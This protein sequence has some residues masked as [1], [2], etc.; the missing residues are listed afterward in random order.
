MNQ[1]GNAG[2]SSL[3]SAQIRSN[4]YF[5]AAAAAAEQELNSYFS[6]LEEKERD[7]EVLVD[8]AQFLA[9]GGYNPFTISRDAVRA[10]MATQPDAHERGTVMD[11]FALE[12]FKY[13]ATLDK[14]LVRVANGEAITPLL[15]YRKPYTKRR[16]QIQI[17]GDLFTNERG[18]LAYPIATRDIDVVTGSATDWESMNR[19]GGIWGDSSMI[20]DTARDGTQGFFIVKKNHNVPVL[21]G[22]TDLMDSFIS[23][24]HASGAVAEYHEVLNS[25]ADVRKDSVRFSVRGQLVFYT[26]FK[27]LEEKRETAKAAEA[28]K[29]ASAVEVT[30]V[31]VEV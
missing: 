26:A 6:S 28:A 9:I 25:N 24:V 7:N 30:P 18:K 17:V 14:N 27:A 11:A 31:T 16:R 21:L 10:L 22:R 15:E 3:T 13:A 23:E 12:N 1:N 2:I 29:A 4:S 8:I 5:G 20:I 19:A